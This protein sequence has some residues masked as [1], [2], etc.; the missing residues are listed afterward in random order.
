MGLSQLL[1][2]PG[3]LLRM[4]LILSSAD[5]VEVRVITSCSSFS[6]IALLLA[7]MS[8]H[9]VHLTLD[10]HHLLCKPG[11]LQLCTL[12]LPLNAQHLLLQ[13]LH[14][15]QQ[16]L[17]G[18][19]E[20]IDQ[21]VFGAGVPTNILSEPFSALV[22]LALFGPGCL[23]RYLQDNLLVLEVLDV[24]ILGAV[25]RLQLSQL[26]FQLQG[27]A[28]QLDLLK[29]ALKTTQLLSQLLD[30]KTTFRSLLREVRLAFLPSRLPWRS[31]MAFS[32]WWQFFRSVPTS[33]LEQ[34]LLFTCCLQHLLQGGELAHGLR[35][36]LPALHRV[37]PL[38]P[39]HC[40]GEYPV[41]PS[42]IT[43]TS[44]KVD[45]ELRV[46][47]WELMVLSAALTLPAPP[48][49]PSLAPSLPGD[50]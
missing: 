19:L 42:D 40:C 1:L 29:L 14:L 28:L 45:T 11:L 13:V 16:A 31:T 33:A 7:T 10:S 27:A 12:L 38:L 47:W 43:P 49:A 17:F 3:H 46:D 20:L 36:N 18:G 9:V 2:E 32:S 23:Q 26:S 24:V 21:L 39:L 48:L 4:L 15:H 22:K 25:V 30:C 34:V 44:D 8:L 6:S 35:G 41:L 37:G 5:S 50:W